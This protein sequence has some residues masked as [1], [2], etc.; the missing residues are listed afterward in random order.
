MNRKNKKII[1]FIEKYRK[2]MFGFFI[3]LLSLIVF[4]I[5]DVTYANNL[6][7]YT[8][9]NIHNPFSISVKLIVKCDFNYKTKKY[10]F[11]KI[12]IMNKKSK[13]YMNFPYGFKKCEIWPVNVKIFGDF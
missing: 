4:L 10:N 2:L 11:Y 7:Q 1:I 5:F 13:I 3:I 9:F 8:K 6:T 12:I